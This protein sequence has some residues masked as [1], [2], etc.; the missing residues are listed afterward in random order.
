MAGPWSFQLG[1]ELV[2]HNPMEGFIGD[3]QGKLLAE[4]ALD[5]EVTGKACGRRQAGLE[6]LEHGGREG[7]LAG[8][9]SRFFVRQ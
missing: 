8:R 4:P 1:L 9:R 3:L 2:M 5:V 7:L 6:L